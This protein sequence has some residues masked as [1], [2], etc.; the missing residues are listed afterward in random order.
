RTPGGGVWIQPPQTVGA[1][2]L[3]D[4]NEIIVPA[5]ILQPPIFDVDADDAV[6]Y[7]AAGA[8]GAPQVRR[9]CAHATGD[10]DAGPLI[11]ALNALEP[12]PGLHVNGRTT[13]AESFGDLA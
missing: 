4:T 2:Y 13:A 7:G 1:F 8:R 9:A 3:P 10:F 5:G 12:L 11:A 6:N